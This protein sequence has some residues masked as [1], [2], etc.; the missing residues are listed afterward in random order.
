[1]DENPGLIQ[2]FMKEHKLTFPVL[3]ASSYVTD[4]LKISGIPQNW[5]VGADG[6]VRLKG[7]GYDS[8]EKWDQG[9]TDAIEN[10]KPTT[11]AVATA[12]PAGN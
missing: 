11:T 3:P 10:N 9:M 4:T 7:I 5:I 8:T 1:M 2:P 6:M 12:K